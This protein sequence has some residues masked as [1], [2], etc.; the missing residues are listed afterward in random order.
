MENNA[1]K[2]VTAEK[3]AMMEAL[4]NAAKELILTNTID[5]V[6]TRFQ[7]EKSILTVQLVPTPFGITTVTRWKNVSRPEYLE[8]MVEMERNG[9]RF[10]MPEA[11]REKLQELIVLL[12]EAEAKVNQK[13]E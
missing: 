5:E 10:G 12:K 7:K 9:E 13:G 1:K 6:E 8:M 2:E 3:A 4:G 11:A